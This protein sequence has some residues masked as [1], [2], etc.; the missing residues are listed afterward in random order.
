[1]TLVTNTPRTDILNLCNLLITRII[2]VIIDSTVY[3]DADEGAVVQRVSMF[4]EWVIV[5]QWQLLH[6]NASIEPTDHH[7]Q[8]Q[9]QRQAAEKLVEDDVE[10]GF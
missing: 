6:E 5:V 9:Q 10:V 1:M 7:H 4:S 2:V 3:H 8:Q